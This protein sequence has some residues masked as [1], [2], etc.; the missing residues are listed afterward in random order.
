ML[1]PAKEY[2]L[3]SWTKH[4]QLL[5]QEI[6]IVHIL[7]NEF[8]NKNIFLENGISGIMWL[9]LMYNNSV[10]DENKI[11]FDTDLFI[12]KITLSTTWIRLK[13]DMDFFRVNSGLNGFCGISLIINSIDKCKL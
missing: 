12:D 6:D 11:E 10:C 8:K 2:N 4:I 7:N 9:L 13:N 1:Y 3:T 5:K